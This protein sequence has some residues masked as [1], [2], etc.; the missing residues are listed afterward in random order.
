ME[1]SYAISHNDYEAYLDNEQV[2][3]ML[4]LGEWIA[5]EIAAYLYED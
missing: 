1:K 5:L 4:T 3:Q 2:I